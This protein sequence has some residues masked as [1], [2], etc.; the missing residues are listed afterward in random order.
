MVPKTEKEIPNVKSVILYSVSGGSE[1][2]RWLQPRLHICFAVTSYPLV[3]SADRPSPSFLVV[4]NSALPLTPN[5][6]KQSVVKFTT[7]W[8]G[9][10]CQ[11]RGWTIS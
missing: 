5:E 9:E 7:Y 8:Q 3:D 2:E 10:F 4:R 1:E 11:F 6:E